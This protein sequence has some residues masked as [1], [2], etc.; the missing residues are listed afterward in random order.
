MSTMPAVAN[1]PS[2]TASPTENSFKQQ[3][4]STAI[5]HAQQDA[6]SRG[7]DVHR[8]QRTMDH[9]Q[10]FGHLTI[11][12]TSQSDSLRAW[13][14][15]PFAELSPPSGMKNAEKELAQPNNSDYQLGAEVGTVKAVYAVGN[16]LLGIGNAVVTPPVRFGN[17]LAN[18]IVEADTA[19]GDSAKFGERAGKAVVSTMKLAGAAEDY[20]ESAREAL[21]KGDYLKPLTDAGELS[22]AAI[23][24]FDALTPGQ[25]SA[26]ITEQV[27]TLGTQ[28]AT[29]KIFSTAAEGV[30]SI[31]QKMEQFKLKSD[32]VRAEFGV[33]IERDTANLAEKHLAGVKNPRFGYEEFES[34]RCADV[35]VQCHRNACVAAVGEML[36]E[37]RLD[38]KTLV[39]ELEAYY[40]PEQRKPE[41]MLSLQ[42]LAAEL[43]KDWEFYTVSKKRNVQ[44]VVLLGHLL[45]KNS[46]FGVTLKA[47]DVDAHAV[48]VDGV[49]AA[50]NRVLIRDPGDGTRHQILLQDFLKNWNGQAVAKVKP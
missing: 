36:S 7:A 29:G 8:T 32:I 46:P 2:E 43:G 10:A 3:G 17:W 16:G 21:H 6:W 33:S 50:N 5:A 48:I 15:N 19:I 47:A 45:S 38:Q 18:T 39:R 23:N 42:H 31:M 37:G 34:E 14:A 40:L 4:V 26:V 27:V 28:I 12:N 44:P 20:I 49:N 13:C 24:K 22:K 11:E 1:H 25:K 9:L 35:V 30:A 41:M